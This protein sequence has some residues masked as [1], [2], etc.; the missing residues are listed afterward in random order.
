MFVLFIQMTCLKLSQ[1]V[2]RCLQMMRRF[3]RLCR[4]SKTEVTF[5]KIWITSKLG[6]AH[7]NK[8]LTQ[9]GRLCV[10]SA[11]RVLGTV[12]SLKQM[13]L[14]NIRCQ[15]TKRLFIIMALSDVCKLN[16]QNK[17]YSFPNPLDIG[18]GF[19]SLG[20]DLNT[21]EQFAVPYNFDVSRTL[22][23]YSIKT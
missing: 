23:P 14:L 15:L 1:A 10:S 5:K 7:G 16:F 6:Q 19:T 17:S 11:A 21:S 8:S 12:L 22:G 18:G 2:S 3:S 13:L 9:R 20:G 4:R